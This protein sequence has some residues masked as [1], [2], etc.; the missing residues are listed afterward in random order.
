MVRGPWAD[1]IHL[2]RAIESALT[3]DRMIHRVLGD[4]GMSF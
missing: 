2:T 3:P 1:E 4:Y